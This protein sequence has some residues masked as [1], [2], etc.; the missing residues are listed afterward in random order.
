MPAAALL[1]TV[2]DAGETGSLRLHGGIG[3]VVRGLLLVLR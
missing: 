2:P 3:R 1:A